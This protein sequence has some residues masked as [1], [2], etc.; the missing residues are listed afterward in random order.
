MR[1]A[2]TS[3]TDSIVNQLNLLAAQQYQLQNQV[4]TGQRIQSP[5]D[6]PAAMSAALN[7][8]TESSNVEQFSQNISTLQNRATLSGN[9]LQQLKTISDQAN[10]IATGVGGATSTQTLQADAAQVTQLIQQ[11]VDVLNAKDGNQYLFGG[12]ASGQPPYSVTT[13]AG[14]NVTGVTYQGN[15]SVSQSQISANSTVSVNVPGENN[16]GSGP[17]GVVSDSRYGADL[18]DHLISL[19]N[20]LLNGDTNA[21][22]TTDL[23]ALTNDENNIIYQ[24]ADNGAVQTRL[25][26]AAS[27]AT[28]SQTALQ[29]SITNVAGADLTQT[30]VQLTQ[31]NNSYQAGLQSASAILQLQQSLLAYLP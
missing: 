12:T 16:T 4:S 21:V 30:L 11:A 22:T 14:G 19:Q 17:R 7:L 29:Q 15:A 8:Q 18:F 26:T 10:E 28:A 9:A 31:A 6:D 3:Y 13:D 20:N 25:D 27:A 2:G 1:I 24:V 5:A 23:P